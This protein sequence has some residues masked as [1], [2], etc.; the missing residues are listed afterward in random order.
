[1]DPITLTLTREILRVE[2]LSRPVADGDAKD[3]T[4]NI[5]RGDVFRDE[6]GKVRFV[7]ASNPLVASGLANHPQFTAIREAFTAMAEQL[8]APAPAPIPAGLHW[9]SEQQSEA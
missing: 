1:M 9:L 4:V 2:I 7:E 5:Q 3:I 8:E 6:A